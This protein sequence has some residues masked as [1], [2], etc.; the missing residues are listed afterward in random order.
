MIVKGLIPSLKA[1]IE[2][3]FM[4]DVERRAGS[5]NC[6]VLIWTDDG[7]VGVVAFCVHGQ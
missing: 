6:P 4:G 3:L 7:S 5:L 1:L 2:I